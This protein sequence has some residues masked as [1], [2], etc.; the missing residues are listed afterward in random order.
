MDVFTLQIIVNANLVGCTFDSVL[1]SHE[2]TL[3]FCT[4]CVKMWMLCKYLVETSNL[5]EASKELV[6][7]WREAYVKFWHVSLLDTLG[8]IFMI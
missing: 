8:T 5:V 3:N 7:Y 2:L 6:Q 1:C 4:C